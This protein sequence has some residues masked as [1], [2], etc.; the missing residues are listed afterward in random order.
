VRQARTG[1]AAPERAARGHNCD[2]V[3]E[4]V[5]ER[6]GKTAGRISAKR[7][8]PTARAAGFTGSDRN[9]RRLAAEAKQAWRRGHHR[10]RRPAVWSPTEHL[11][12]DWGS[13]GGL[14]VFCAVLAWS[15]F[16]FVRFAADERAETMSAM[17]DECFEVLG[18]VLAGRTG[19]RRS[20]PSRS[21]DERSRKI[22]KAKPAEDDLPFSA[23]SLAKL[24]DS[25]SHWPFD[26]RG[27]FLPEHTTAVSLLDSST[28]PTSSSPA[29][30]PTTC[31][32][33][34]PKEEPP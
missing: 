34:E 1:R 12:I 18:G 13:L 23:W 21:G 8:L 28:T 32:R 14:Q 29:A 3:A 33:P 27:R 16:R 19:G 24:A 31:A 11:V 15:R 2:G 30:T 7:L 26:Q 20:S 4:L 6:A 25:L 5:A 10:G 17:L 9:F 22:A